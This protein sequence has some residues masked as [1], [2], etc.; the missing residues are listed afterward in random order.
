MTQYVRYI[1]KTRDYYRSQGYE[2]PYQ[3][4]HHDKVPFTEVSK[5]LAR[6][7]VGLISTS[8]ISVRGHEPGAEEDGGDQHMGLLGGVYSIPA[9]TPLDAL[10]SPSHSYDQ[11]ATTLEDVNAFFPGA[12]LQNAA[13]NGRIES[14]ADDY[15]GVYNAYSQRLTN[16]RDAPEV[17]RRC[18]ALGVDVA[19]LVPV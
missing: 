4:A 14:V 16:E 3:W 8:E 6:C 10:Y 9:N 17:L 5:P 13:S 18:R 1:D 7:R 11:F 15:I 2:R 19:V 12:A